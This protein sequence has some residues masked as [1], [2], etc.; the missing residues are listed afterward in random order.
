MFYVHK[1]TTELC[2]G[3]PEEGGWWYD[4]LDPINPSDPEYEQPVVFESEDD[5]YEFCRTMNE[6]ERERRS[7]LRYQY[8]SVLS[9]KEEFYAYTISESKT[10][11]PIPAHRPRYE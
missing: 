10:I 4:Q 11:G 6:R 2:S 3:G 7:T 1:M 5:A 8:T 9:H